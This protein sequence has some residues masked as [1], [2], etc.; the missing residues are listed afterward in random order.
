MSPP[1][2]GLSEC[3]D[4]LCVQ[5]CGKVREW[6]TDMFQPAGGVAHNPEG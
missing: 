5:A 3:R 4:S 2:L 6:E 1:P